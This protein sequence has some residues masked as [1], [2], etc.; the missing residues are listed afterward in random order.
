MNR[1]RSPFSL[2]VFPGY[3]WCGPG[4]S[5]PGRPINDV[6]A[7]CY[8]HDRCLS[9][10]YSPCECDKKFMNCLRSKI[11]PNTQKGRQ[12]LLMYQFMK[13]KTPFTC[14]PSKLR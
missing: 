13:L 14:P 6:D 4:C 2:C 10:G 1:R 9:Q 11:N 3:K 8:Q 7:C 5:G 12:A